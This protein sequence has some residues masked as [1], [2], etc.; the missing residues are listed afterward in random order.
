MYLMLEIEEFKIAVMS[1]TLSWYILQFQ[2]FAFFAA[3]FSVELE[4][5]FHG[6]LVD[7][8]LELLSRDVSQWRSVE[9]DWWR[10]ISL[11]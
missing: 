3:F 1:R 11:K 10:R 2:A 7:H 6:S 4:G 9:G 5:A 8:S